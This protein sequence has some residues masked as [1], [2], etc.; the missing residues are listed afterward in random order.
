MF[1]EPCQG[2]KPLT[3]FIDVFKLFTIYDYLDFRRQRP[4]YYPGQQPGG[5]YIPAG[6]QRRFNHIAIP[7]QCLPF[8]PLVAHIGP[9]RTVHTRGCEND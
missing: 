2:F 7:N 5:G 3:R 6:M 1:P 8:P 4:G 9:F